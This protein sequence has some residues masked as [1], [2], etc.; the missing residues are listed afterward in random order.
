MPQSLK[1]A[2]TTAAAKSYNFQSKSWVKR[3]ILYAR[4]HRAHQ[5]VHETLQRL[6]DYLQ[7]K[8][9]ET[10]QDEDTANGFNLDLSIL[11]RANMDHNHDLII[12]VGGDGSLLSA[13]RIAINV[14][15]PVLGINRG[16]LGFLTDIA[17]Q[18]IEKELDAILHGS[19]LEEK[20]FLLTAK[21]SDEAIQYCDLN[22]YH[23]TELQAKKY[24]T[25]FESEALNDVVLNGGIETHLIE[26]DIY[27]NE[28]FVSHE[29]SDG[30]ILATPTGSTA[31]A[32]SAGGP[33]MHPQLDAIVIVPMFSHSFS[34]R[35]LVINSSAK[36]V[37]RISD[38]NEN[39]LQ[40]SCDGHESQIV[41]PK[42]SIIVQ[43]A[44][45]QLRLLH[46]ANYHY[47]D[48]L[49]IKLGWGYKPK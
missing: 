48:T 18:D 12:V 42:Q 19:F 10:Y 24:K 35:P 21:I 36:I 15:V 7:Q 37:L 40:L 34:A 16:R 49:R 32:M 8:K 11:P 31:Y 20:R 45:K 26:F 39:D 4:Q 41:K 30:L 47:Y 28:Q 5:G 13:A 22:Q 43:K 3:V 17:P 44:S 9:I 14:D 23:D 1:I 46:P 33:I 2:K 27:I 6:I 29:R 38:S 25:Y